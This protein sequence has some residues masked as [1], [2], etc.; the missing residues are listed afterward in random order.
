MSLEFIL[1]LRQNNVFEDVI[2]TFYGF[3]DN[4]GNVRKI[5]K[6]RKFWI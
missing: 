1:F 6:K 5:R 4:N 3:N 2:L